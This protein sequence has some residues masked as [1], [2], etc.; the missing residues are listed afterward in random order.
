MY[1]VLMVI[2]VVVVF[3]STTIGTSYGCWFGKVQHRWYTST[4]AITNNGMRY[5][6][7]RTTLNSTPLCVNLILPL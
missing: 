7:E 5:E 3:D 6:N 2:L 4:D 1:L